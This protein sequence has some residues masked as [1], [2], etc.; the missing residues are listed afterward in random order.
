MGTE[1]GLLFPIETDKMIFNAGLTG[2]M[3]VKIGQVLRPYI[4]LEADYCTNYS[5]VA[6]AGFGCDFILARVICLNVN[7]SYNC[8]VDLMQYLNTDARMEKISSGQDLERPLSFL[9]NF[10]LGIGFAW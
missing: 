8:N 6:K 7:Y 3:N 5:G 10:L 2:G 9:H 1:F 4:F